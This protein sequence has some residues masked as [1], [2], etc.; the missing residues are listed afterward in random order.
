MRLVDLDVIYEDVSRIGR[1]IT[2]MPDGIVRGTA[3]TAWLDVVTYLHKIETISDAKLISM[4][5]VDPDF[6]F[7]CVDALSRML[8]DPE[9]D[10]KTLL[11]AI[12]E[13]NKLQ[14]NCK[15]EEE[16]K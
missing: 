16:K 14:R 2:N 3:L 7:K 8:A 10:R 11:C 1:E 12:Q 15:K 4:Y 5:S 9:Y 13:L 6:K